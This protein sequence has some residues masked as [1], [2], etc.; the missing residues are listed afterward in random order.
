MTNNGRL[1][2]K[3]ENI[4]TSFKL[5]GGEG[6]GRGNGEMVGIRRRSVSYGGRV[7]GF[8]DN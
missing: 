2:Q 1:T 5:K 4:P 6:G 7:G 8:L 3:R